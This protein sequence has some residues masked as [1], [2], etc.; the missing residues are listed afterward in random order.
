MNDIAWVES[1]LQMIIRGFP[2]PFPND[3]NAPNDHE[4]KILGDLA[5]RTH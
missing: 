2:P 4:D 1:A 5:I 3:N